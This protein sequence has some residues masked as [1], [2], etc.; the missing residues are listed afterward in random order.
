MIR[1][2][3]GTALPRLLDRL[4]RELTGGAADH[5]QPQARPGARD[6]QGRLL[7]DHAPVLTV[8]PGDTVT[9][10]SLDASGY[11]AR[12]SFPGRGP[13]PDVPRPAGTA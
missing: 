3:I 13:A 5:D 10:G 8:D 12:Q 4:Q 7:P 9:V 1:E 6:H 2:P 11:L